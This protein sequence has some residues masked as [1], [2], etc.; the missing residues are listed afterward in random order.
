MTSEAG[1]LALCGKCETPV[2]DAKNS[3]LVIAPSGNR[4]VVQ[5]GVGDLSDDVAARPREPK[6]V[7]LE[8]V[9]VGVKERSISTQ[10]KVVLCP[11]WQP[12]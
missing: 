3:D 10:R 11:S 5:R 6:R 12:F 1:P 7:S 2:T 4:D 8:S 9:L